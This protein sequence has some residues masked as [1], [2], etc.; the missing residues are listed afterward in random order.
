MVAWYEDCLLFSYNNNEFFEK[1]HTL[2]LHSYEELQIKRMNS[3]V[4][5]IN[6]KW[7]DKIRI[8]D[9]IFSKE[10]IEVDFWIYCQENILCC[11]GNSES[12]ISYAVSEISQKTSTLIE[13]I[14]TYEIWKSQIIFD[15]YNKVDWIGEMT[16]IH[17]NNKFSIIERG[18]KKIP[19]KDLNP[20]V[21]NKYLNSEGVT[22]ISFIINKTPYNIGTNSVISFPTTTNENQNFEIINLIV[23]EI[24]QIK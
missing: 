16:S 3:N 21:I 9:K 15:I 13:K 17:I 2:T 10:A 20:D 14:D 23:K 8:H 12:A 1:L 24:S 19:V 7:I 22:S 11:F 18:I 6:Y 4:L 5:A